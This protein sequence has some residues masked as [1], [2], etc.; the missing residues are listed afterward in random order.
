MNTCGLYKGETRAVKKQR[1]LQRDKRQCVWQ[2]NPT[3]IQRAMG[4]IRQRTQDGR[5]VTVK[6]Q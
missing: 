3:S 5:R 2:D 1:L 6:A 4:K